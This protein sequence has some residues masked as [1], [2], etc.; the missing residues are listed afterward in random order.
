MHRVDAIAL[1]CQIRIEPHRRRYS[2]SRGGAAARPVRRHRALGGHAQAA[3]VRQPSST[4]VPG[5]TGSTDDRPAGAVHLRPGDRLDQVLQ[6]P[7]RRRGPVAVAV[8]RDGVRG[9]WTAGCTVQQVPWSKETS[10]PLPV[11]VWRETIDPHFP[12]SAWL[13]V[14]RETLDALHRF[15]TRHALP[16][17]DSTVTALLDQAA[18][19]E[20]KEERHDGR[21]TRRRPSHCWCSGDPVVAR[22]Q[23]VLGYAGCE[24]GG[25]GEGAIGVFALGYGVGTRQGG[26][27]AACAKRRFASPWLIRRDLQPWVRTQCRHQRCDGTSPSSASWSPFRAVHPVLGLGEG[28]EEL[29]P[30][31]TRR[32]RRVR[33]TGRAALSYRRRSRAPRRRP[34]RG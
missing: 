9:A 16:T 1:R 21:A 13:R 20:P 34:A 3:A 15:K 33:N 29:A 17:W 10:C 28:V 24:W 6:R 19:Q 18:D 2:D 25:H 31:A 22:H 27:D 14:R 12:N 8:Q 7:G 5:F 4:M 23:A 32:D 26:D 11:E 30:R